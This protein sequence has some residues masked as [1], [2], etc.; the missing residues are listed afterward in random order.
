[1]LVFYFLGDQLPYA[2]AITK[3][4]DSINCLP[5][6][7]PST[8]GQFPVLPEALLPHGRMTAQPT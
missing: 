7:S 6:A 3:W 4:I 2:V 5:S 8:M 1:M